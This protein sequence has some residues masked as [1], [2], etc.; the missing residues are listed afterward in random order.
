MVSRVLEGAEATGR[1]YELF[2]LRSS[3]YQEAEKVLG[4]MMTPSI[5]IPWKS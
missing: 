5:C 1:P 2:S 4:L 3:I